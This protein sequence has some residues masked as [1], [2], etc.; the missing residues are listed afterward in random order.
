MTTESRLSAIA[1]TTQLHRT[2][3]N[4]SPIEVRLGPR[5]QRSARTPAMK[6]SETATRIAFDRGS[7]SR[8]ILMQSV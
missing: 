4:A 2:W 5:H 3:A 8:R 1:M 7:D 6:T